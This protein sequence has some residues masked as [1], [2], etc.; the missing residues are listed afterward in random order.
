MAVI[1]TF[2]VQYYNASGNLYGTYEIKF[3]DTN[4]GTEDSPEYY[5]SSPGLS[6]YT[7]AWVEDVA[8]EV[9]EDGSFITYT[10]WDNTLFTASGPLRVYSNDFEGSTGGNG[11]GSGPSTDPVGQVRIDL[12]DIDGNLAW[13]E[14]VD[15]YNAGTPET[16]YVSG[17]LIIPSH[18]ESLQDVHEW[19][20]V[21]GAYWAYGWCTYDSVPA[22]GYS[23]Y[24]VLYQGYYNGGVYYDGNGKTDFV[25][26]NDL[27][28]IPNNASG[29]W[30]RDIVVTTDYIVGETTNDS[31]G[32]FQYWYDE[33]NGTSYA[34]GETI[35][36]LW[37]SIT[38][39]AIWSG[40]ENPPSGSYFTITYY[41]PSGC[42][43]THYEQIPYEDYNG[44]AE[45][46]PSDHLWEK[47]ANGEYFECWYDD[48][49]QEY[50]PQEYYYITS[51]LTLYAR[52]S[53]HDTSSL[54]AYIKEGGVWKKGTI[55]IKNDS[56]KQGKPYTKNSQWR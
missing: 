43:D 27:E 11:G 51:D 20:Y 36:G 45:F 37:G 1:Y 15:L 30:S 54:K 55:F 42:Y 41:D 8:M 33:Q 10:D 47:E 49:G 34:P 40:G 52:W 2:N 5:S 6:G 21:D 53:Y 19:T 16:P 50:Y 39:K 18:I 12:L 9:L 23:V 35:Y 17:N 46:Y 28:T 3:Y 26:E 4:Y 25:P 56:W 44:Y 29:G 32:I 14:D 31:G 38:L 22:E 24:Q 7:N 48:Y 13:S